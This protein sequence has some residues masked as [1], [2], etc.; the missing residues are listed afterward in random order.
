MV[1]YRRI[2]PPIFI[3]WLYGSYRSFGISKVLVAHLEFHNAIAGAKALHGVFFDIN[4]EAI[5]AEVGRAAALAIGI[6]TGVVY[7]TGNV[8][9]SLA[10]VQGF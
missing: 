6:C 3:Q 2:N 7:F 8:A 4:Q 5:T 9:I 1:K 10:Q